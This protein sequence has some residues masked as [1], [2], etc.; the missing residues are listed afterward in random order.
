MSQENV[1]LVRAVHEG[2]GR[3]DFKIVPELF[4]SDFSWEQPAE[5]VEPG[6]RHGDEIGNSLRHLFEVYDDYRIDAEEFIDRGDEV[7]VMARS[8]AIAKASGIELDQSFA[9]VWTVR[10]GLLIRLRVFT[11]RAKALEAATD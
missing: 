9:F 2:W 6:S 7:V 4:S 5:A 8:K 3:G 1:E 11:E 10:E